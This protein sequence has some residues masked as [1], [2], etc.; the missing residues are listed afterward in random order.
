MALTHYPQLSGSKAALLQFVDKMK[1]WGI[2]YKTEG[3]TFDPIWGGFLGRI[4]QL[5]YLTPYAK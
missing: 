2:S 5:G 1:K 3:I 4:A